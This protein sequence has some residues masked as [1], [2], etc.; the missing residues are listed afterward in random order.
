MKKLLYKTRKF[1]GEH[2][3]KLANSVIDVAL[4]ANKALLE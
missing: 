4:K 3:R 1:K 2:E